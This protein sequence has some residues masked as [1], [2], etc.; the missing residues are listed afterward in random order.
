MTSRDDQSLGGLT[1][2]LGLKSVAS[3]AD[4]LSGKDLGGVM[5]VCPIG[6]GGMGR[7]YEGQQHKPRRKVAVKVMR[8]GCM[9]HE[10]Q[11]RFEREWETLGRLQH[12]YIAQIYSAGSCSV[13]GVQVPYIVMEFIADGLK[14]TTFAK[15]QQLPLKA[16]LKLFRKVCDAMAHAHENGVIHRDLKPSNILVKPKAIPKVIDFGVARS[17]EPAA[18]PV[19]AITEVGQAVGTKEYMSPEQFAGD[20]SQVTAAADVYSLGVILYEL[21]TGE[22]PHDVRRK[23]IHEA[24]KEVR[25]H[26]IVPPSQ[27]NPDIPSGIAEIIEKCLR[28]DRSQRF[29]SGTELAQALDA[30]RRGRP[31]RVKAPRSASITE[32]VAATRHPTV[33]VRNAEI[34]AC[35]HCERMFQASSS[36]LG[37][38]IR[39]R[40]CRQI[41]HVPKDTTNVPLAR[42]SRDATEGD[43]A[44]PPATAA[45]V[46]GKDARRCPACRRAFT[47]QPKYA[48]TRIRCR[49]CKAMFRVPASEGPVEGIAS[50]QE[51]PVLSAPCSTVSK[52]IGDVLDDWIP[53]E[54]V[55]SVVRPRVVA[56]TRFQAAGRHPNPF[57]RPFL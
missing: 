19:T 10:G 17:I 34:L 40:G 47:M 51:S 1:E 18:E 54:N 45:V 15:T 30:Q 33:V 5:L 13:G 36:V 20:S 3:A 35:P 49:G 46:D 37:K 32:N 39:C 56:R 25:L 50:G 11:R 53:E 38:K 24:A 7:V 31:P 8:P 44:L 4:S 27:R 41:F 57:R 28:K 29:A 12:E 2:E 6:E 21:L 52:D 22:L 55:V 23:P 48:G 9:S 14:L 42:S 43:N 26:A 16:R